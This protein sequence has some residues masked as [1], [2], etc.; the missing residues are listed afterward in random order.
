MSGGQLS[1]DADT[2]KRSIVELPNMQHTLV[3]FVNSIRSSSDILVLD[4]FESRQ[5][6][7]HSRPNAMGSPLTV[8]I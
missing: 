3:L 2:T 8:N 1:A 4:W 6:A 5:R 7:D